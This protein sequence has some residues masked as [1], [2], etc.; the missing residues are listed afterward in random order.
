MSPLQKVRLEVEELRERCRGEACVV[1][2]RGVTEAAKAQESVQKGVA[3]MQLKQPTPT[4]VATDIPGLN[5]CLFELLVFPVCH[6]GTPWKEMRLFSVKTNTMCFVLPSLSDSLSFV[7]VSCT[8]VSIF[9][10]QPGQVCICNRS[11]RI[12]GTPTDSTNSSSIPINPLPTNCVGHSSVLNHIPVF[13]WAVE[14]EDWEEKLVLLWIMEPEI[15][16]LILLV[17]TYKLPFRGGPTLFSCKII[18][19]W[20]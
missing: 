16:P 9:A 11:T 17:Q 1:H 12:K 5:W 3:S 4:K 6:Q 15:A 2:A 14:E 10:R 7:W 18:V 8:G 19:N 20:V 13:E